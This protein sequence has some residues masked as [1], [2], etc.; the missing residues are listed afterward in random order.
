MPEFGST[1]GEP[2]LWALVALLRRL[3]ETTAE[4]YGRLS[5]EP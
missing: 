3:P 5:R 2:E 4:E 1:H